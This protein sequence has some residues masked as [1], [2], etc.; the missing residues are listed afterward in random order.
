MAGLLFAKRR[1]N[2]KRLPQQIDVA[3][4]IHAYDLDNLYPQ[5]IKELH[6]RSP[7][8]KAAVEVQADFIAG[9]GW[10]NET[11]GETI[12]NSDGYTFNDLLNFLSQ[13]YSLFLG[14]SIHF[15]FNGLGQVIEANFLPFE[16]VR[17][18]LP[19]PMGKHSNV[20]VSNNWE[21]ASQKNK[22][23]SLISPVTYPLYNPFTAGMEALVGPGGQVLYFTTV[24]DLYPL[25]SIDAIA[26]TV[27]TDA[28]I[29]RYELNNTRSG[30]HGGLF[31]HYPNDVEEGSEEE[32]RIVETVSQMSGSDGPGIMVTFGDEEYKLSDNIVT[33]DDPTI[34]DLY[35][36]VSSRIEKTVVQ[37]FAIPQ[38]LVGI[39]ADSSVFSQAVMQDGFIYYN[40][41]TRK[42]RN[43]MARIF[44]S[45][46]EL[47]HE[48]PLDF[49]KIKEREYITP[50]FRQEVVQPGQE[51][52]EAETE[53][54]EKD[55]KL[56]AIY[57]SSRYNRY[58]TSGY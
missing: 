4:E 23:D 40:I 58:A 16:Y 48:G 21:Q 50:V 43:N 44:K 9:D 3:K 2:Y 53:E 26:D 45:F 47:W 39:Q 41:R 19:S 34:S 5:R 13:D 12:A 10:E 7:L 29:M 14:L 22:L 1:V 6:Y 32:D 54:Q 30:Y 49:G 56:T 37:N 42:F 33:I 27:Q 25:S 20:K 24:P 36:G 35:E 18:G 8:A 28:E 38:Q 46:G 52:Q 15:N 51:S 57:G 11:A 31:Y 17:F 55:A